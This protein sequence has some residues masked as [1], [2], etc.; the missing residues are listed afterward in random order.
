MFN[1]FAS[2]AELPP[3]AVSFCTPLKLR[4]GLVV[5]AVAPNCY[6]F[7]KFWGFW[8]SLEVQGL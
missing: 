7:G 1:Q 8:R 4:G 5:I 3:G 2:S 6:D